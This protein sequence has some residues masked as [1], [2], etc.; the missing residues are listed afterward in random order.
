VTSMRR[1]LLV[2]VMLAVAVP[3]SADR[4]DDAKAEVAFGIQVARKGLWKEALSRWQKATERDPNDAEGWNDLA[5]GYEQIGNF[6][7][8]R[9]AYEKALRIEKDNEYIRQNYA[10]FFEIYDR[11]HARSNGR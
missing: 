7:G 8:A 2:A 5:V 3:L 1:A 9:Q 6:D 11:Q 4:R 10:A